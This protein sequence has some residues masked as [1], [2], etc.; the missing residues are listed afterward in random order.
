MTYLRSIKLIEPFGRAEARQWPTITYDFITLFA[1]VR[2]LLS[3]FRYHQLYQNSSKK[4]IAIHIHNNEHVCTYVCARKSV[5]LCMFM[6]NVVRRGAHG[7]R[8]VTH[9]VILEE[10]Q[11]W[12]WH[13]AAG[14]A[15]ML[16]RLPNA[17][18][19]A[20]WTHLAQLHLYGSLFVFIGCWSNFLSSREL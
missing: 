14:R 6:L 9:D 15:A 17:D 20:K 8:D 5:H 11:R 18:W 16:D 12:T 4:F 2:C 7:P 10:Y 13:R 19:F 3:L 1:F